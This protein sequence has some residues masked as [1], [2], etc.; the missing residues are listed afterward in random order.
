MLLIGVL[1]TGPLMVVISNSLF[2]YATGVQV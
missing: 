2:G 1:A